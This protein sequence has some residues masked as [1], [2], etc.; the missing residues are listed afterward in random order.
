MRLSVH[1]ALKPARTDSSLLHIIKRPRKEC[2]AYFRGLLCPLSSERN[3]L[4]CCTL[5]ERRFIPARIKTKAVTANASVI[6][7]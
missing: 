2:S 6:A 1:A 5:T 4:Q 3:Y 7:V